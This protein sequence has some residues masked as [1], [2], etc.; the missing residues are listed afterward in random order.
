MASSSI[1]ETTAFENQTRDFDVRTPPPS[2]PLRGPR[3]CQPCRKKY[4]PSVRLDDK[5]GLKNAS[6][7]HSETENL[8]GT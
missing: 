1:R 5:T 3:R 7:S 8:L 4:L 2:P 6:D